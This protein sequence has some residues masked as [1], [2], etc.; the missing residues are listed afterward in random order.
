MIRPFFL[1]RT[2]AQVLTFLPPMSQIIVPVSMSIVQKK[3]YRSILAKNPDLMKAIFSAERSLKQGERGSLSNIL[4]QLR[5]CLC[6]PFVYSKSIEEPNVGMAASHRNLV[7]ASS[8]LK[9]LELLLPELKKRGHRVL[10]NARHCRRLHGRHGLRFPTP[11]R[12]HGCASEAEA[13]RRVQCSRQLSFRLFTF[14][15]RRRCWNQP[16]HCRHSHYPR[17]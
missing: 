13:Y 9:L 15:P 6:H 7:D 1:R 5:K 4:M 3:L 2:K 17:S 8:K 12:Q 10:S 16:R 14:H 11:G